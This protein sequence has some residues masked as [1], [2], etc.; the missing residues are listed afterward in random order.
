VANRVPI[1]A[2]GPYALRNYIAR[3]QG[4]YTNGTPAGAFRGFGVPQSAVAQE[5]LFDELAEK[6]GQEA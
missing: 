3:A 5:V 1:H 4:V 2:S 6:L